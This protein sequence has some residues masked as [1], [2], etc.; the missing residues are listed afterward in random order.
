MVFSDF[1]DS[2]VCIC[3]ARAA[4]MMLDGSM[5]EDAGMAG[6]GSAFLLSAVNFSPVP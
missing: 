2:M 1:S 4:F 5:G 3:A 6:D